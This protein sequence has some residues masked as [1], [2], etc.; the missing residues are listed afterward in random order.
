M[1]LC[2]ISNFLNHHQIPLCLELEKKFGKGNFSFIQTEN[3]PYSRIKLGYEDYSN[4]YSFVIDYAKKSDEAEKAI[5]QSDVIINTQALGIRYIKKGVKKNQIFFWY[6]ERLYKDYS[7]LK[8]IIKYFR[9]LYWFSRIRKEN[10]YCLCASSFCYQDM[11]KTRE[12][13]F[14]DKCFKWGY[15]PQFNNTESIRNNVSTKLNLLFVGRLINWKHPEKMIAIANYLKSKS[16]PFNIKIIGD[17]EMKNVLSKKI[18]ANDFSSN[19]LLLGSK[20]SNEIVE[21]YKTSDIFCFLSDR[22][23][24][25]GAVLNEAMSVGCVPL[26]DREAGSTLF[27]VKDGANG[28]V[29]DDEKSMKEKLDTIIER[30]KTSSL[31]SLQ[32]NAISTI[33]DLWNAKVAAKRFFNV[34]TAIRNGLPITDYDDGPMAR[35]F[36]KQ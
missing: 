26:A 8:T 33:D 10:Q 11:C 18:S 17:G 23:E 35:I 6:N 24:G 22:R 28:Y 5:E 21:Y 2:F 27:L 13:I 19:I 29:F 25:W 31:L 4:K 16:I 20:P 1:K 12:D 9:S 30:W 34:V 3:V 36:S 14:S 15:F 7:P 32:Q